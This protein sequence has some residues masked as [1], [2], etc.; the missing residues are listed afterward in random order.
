[1]RAIMNLPGRLLINHSLLPLSLSP[2]KRAGEKIW[3]EVIFLQGVESDGGVKSKI[4]HFSTPCYGTDG[5]VSHRR[6]VC[7]GC[8]KDGNAGDSAAP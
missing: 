1:M 6:K 4:V 8:V 7:K 3:N 5:M 2:R